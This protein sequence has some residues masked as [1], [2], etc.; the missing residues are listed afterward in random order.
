MGD[1][2]DIEREI[3]AS[4]LTEAGSDDEIER[5][6]VEL[7]ETNRGVLAL[8]AELD[9]HARKLA[10]ADERKDQFLA[11]LAHELRNPLAV[12]DLALDSLEGSPEVFVLRRQIRHLTRLVDDLL[13]MSR[14]ARGK[15]AL[16]MRPLDLVT[17]VDETVRDGAVLLRTMGSSLDWT[18]PADAIVVE[19]DAVRLTQVV[20]NLLHN[21]GKYSPAGSRVRVTLDELDGQ[22]RLRVADEGRG[23]TA[24]E[25]KRI[26]ELFVQA[27]VA[28]EHG[29]SGL[30]IGLTLVRQ[31]TQM[32][33][34]QVQ[35][36]SEGRGR[37]SVFS[38]CLPL[39]DATPQP[40]PRTPAPA[41]LDARVLLVEDDDDLRE[42]LAAKLERRGLTVVTATDG[43]EALTQLEEGAPDVVVTDL[44]LPAM[45]GHTLARAIRRSHP[46][47]PL[48]A[49]SG[50]GARRDRE[51][52]A[53]A[54]FAKHFVKPI[55]VDDLVSA[56]A[57]LVQP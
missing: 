6:R 18:A 57:T 40:R 37:G 26:F 1:E 8:Y 48:V 36:E 56:L 2:P 28:A 33:G 11:L 15:I 23:L 14:I 43:R 34:G 39:S 3:G 10:A 53:A 30:G 44:G 21:A 7:A 17:L 20:T 22:A 50:Y 25:R 16:E 24:N 32:Q 47:L 27:D 52:S 12:A 29:A 38:V 46:G 4:H 19:G 35:V 54:G 45:D 13:D 5:L 41:S 49:L 42:L 9:Q 31:L 51:R 55:A